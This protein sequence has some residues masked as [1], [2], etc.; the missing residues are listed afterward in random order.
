MLT[1]IPMKGLFSWKSCLINFA[2][3]TDNDKMWDLPCDC[4]RQI[5]GGLVLIIYY[6]FAC[7]LTPSAQTMRRCGTYPVIGKEKSLVASLNAWFS[8]IRLTKSC[9]RVL[10]CFTF[11]IC[12]SWWIKDSTCA[13]EG[14]KSTL[15]GFAVNIWVQHGK[16]MKET[17]FFD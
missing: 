5:T 11:F 6:V 15:D 17:L 12:F 3:F 10:I 14:C 8:T 16:F 13:F 2:F 9:S 7:M 1:Y 4:Q